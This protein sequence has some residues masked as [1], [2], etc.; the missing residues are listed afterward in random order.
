MAKLATALVS[1]YKSKLVDQ[2]VS[3]MKSEGQ[4]QE[5]EVH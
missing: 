5:F 1:G 2:L 4:I 3:K